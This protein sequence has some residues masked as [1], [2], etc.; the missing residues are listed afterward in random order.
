M[1]SETQKDLLELLKEIDDICTRND[2]DFYLAGGSMIGAVRHAGFLPWDDDA[3]VHMTKEAAE[4]FASLSSEFLPG[5]IVVNKDTHRDNAAVHWRYMNTNKT[6]MLKSYSADVPQGQFVDIFILNPITN[7]VSKHAEIVRKY[8]LYSEWVVN[9]FPINS[10]RDDSIFDEYKILREREKTEGYDKIRK[11]LEDE[12]F[13]F[14]GEECDYYLVRSPGSP[15]PVFHKSLWGKPRRVPFED[16]TM[17]VAEKSEEILSMSYGDRWVD[18]PEVVDRISHTFVSDQEIPCDLYDIDVKKFV[19]K[20]SFLKFTY[21]KK[22]LWFAHAKD[23]NLANSTGREVIQIPILEKIREKIGNNTVDELIKGRKYTEL[24][25]IFSEYYRTQFSDFKY[26]RLYFDMPEDYL[27]GAL[28][29]LMIQG[30]YNKASKVLRMKESR[31]GEPVKP[32]LKQLYDLC[33]ALTELSNCIYVY[34]DLDRAKE[35][36]SKWFPLFPDCLTLIRADVYLLLQEKEPDVD[37]IREKITTG[38]SLFVEDGELLKYWGDTY[39]IEGDEKTV[40]R[41]YS[42]ALGTVTNGLLMTE[43]KKYMENSTHA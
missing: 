28:Y 10:V 29:P 22:D 4:K 32:G 38:L 2:I 18:V 20:K 3:D 19:D 27:L 1:L 11:E 7:D 42:R 43:M 24:K 26:Y 34:K 41:L 25:E 39:K 6:T 14:P 13:E 31:S 9:H 40:R 17:P 37:L 35:I 30:S 8:Y 5:R 23:R 15:N 21:E 33:S 16:T 12:I 36:V